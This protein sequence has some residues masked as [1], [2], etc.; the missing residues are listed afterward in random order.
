MILLTNV[1]SMP[2]WNYTVASS[3]PQV[4][5]GTSANNYTFVTTANMTVCTNSIKHM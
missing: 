5:Y 3:N 1:F 4:E 2:D